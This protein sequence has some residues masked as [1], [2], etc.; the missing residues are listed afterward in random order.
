MT[1]ERLDKELFQP[2]EV[3]EANVVL[4]GASTSRG[5]TLI[6]ATDIGGEVV[7]DYVIDEFEDPAPAPGPIYA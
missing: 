5:F 4:G 7:N 2:L 1:L 6:G 3:T